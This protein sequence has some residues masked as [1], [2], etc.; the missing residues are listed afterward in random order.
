MKKP[1]SFT[2]DIVPAV[3]YLVLQGY[4]RRHA[5]LIVLDALAREAHHGR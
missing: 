3:E 4:T 1:I 2:Y 5:L